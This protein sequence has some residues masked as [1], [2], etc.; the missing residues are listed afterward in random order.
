M[1]IKSFTWLGLVRESMYY[2]F[3]ESNRNIDSNKA[4]EVRNYLEEDASNE[5][6]IILSSNGGDAFLAK[7]I[8]DLLSAYKSR[9]TVEIVGLAASSGSILA[10]GLGEKTYV[11]ESSQI[12]I[13]APESFTEGNLRD[14]E[15]K[16]TTF[17]SSHSVMR[18]LYG[19]NSKLTAVELDSVFNDYKELWYTASEA[20]AK[21]LAVKVLES[22]AKVAEVIQEFEEEEDD[23]VEERR[24]RLVS[25]F[26]LDKIASA[27]GINLGEA[28]QYTLSNDSSTTDTE[29][30]VSDK[31]KALQ[32]EVDALKDK[33]KTL[34][35]NNT[36]IQAKLDAKI[37][38]ANKA[39]NTALVDTAIA[40]KKIGKDEREVWM[41][42][43]EDGGAVV[44]DIL[45]TSKPILNSGE[46]GSDVDKP[47]VSLEDIPPDVVAAYKEAK[48]TD[49]QIVE[50]WEKDR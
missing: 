49:E 46:T 6:N 34:E 44:A 13:H 47:T 3:F 35:A 41:K 45:K 36:A 5:A 14:H 15:N 42:R 19:S 1:A 22:N 21:G 16:V 37:K 2:F 31:E 25:K 40:E 29:V 9:I 39:S 24:I 33:V 23:A 11:R 28:A 38:E 20:V 8:V 48:Y 26:P 17:E 7:R 27:L 43:L 4:L 12:M 30:E 32:A 10:A 50:A 18:N